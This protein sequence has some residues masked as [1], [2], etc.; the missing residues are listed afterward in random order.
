M[1]Y[2]VLL[3]LHAISAGVLAG[4]SIHNGLMGYA[5]LRRGEM[6]NVRLRRL[7][8][9]VLGIA[10]ILTFSLGALVYPTFRVEVRAAWLDEQ[11]PWVTMLFE[12]KEHLLAIAGLVL[13]YLVP[14]SLR[15]SPEPIG[16]DHRLCATASLFVMGVVSYALL[17]GLFTTT[18]S[19][20]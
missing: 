6:G 10:F 20:S 14:S 19:P 18:L 9:A 11:L 8:P 5:F 17:I 15:L 12:I 13:L 1:G 7:Y 3:V 16:A 4:A 2:S